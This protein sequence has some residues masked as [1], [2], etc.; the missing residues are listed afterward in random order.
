VILVRK[1]E[2]LAWHFLRLQDIERREALRDGQAIIQFAVDGLSF[3]LA[4]CPDFSS[5]NG[6]PIII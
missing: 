6:G 4:K 3:L 1:H 5:K 2:Q